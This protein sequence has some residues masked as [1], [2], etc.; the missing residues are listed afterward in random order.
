MFVITEMYRVFLGRWRDYVR[1]AR[2]AHP[3]WFG[4]RDERGRALSR[5]LDALEGCRREDAPRMQ[6][7]VVALMSEMQAFMREHPPPAPPDPP[8]DT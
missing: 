3:E 7:R 5:A 4:R 6:A 2:V 8:R 1:A